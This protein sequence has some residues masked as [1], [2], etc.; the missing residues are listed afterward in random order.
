MSGIIFEFNI[1]VYI[2]YGGDKKKV[3]LEDT[4]QGK[5]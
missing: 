2:F 4:T 3:Y 5:L 1:P